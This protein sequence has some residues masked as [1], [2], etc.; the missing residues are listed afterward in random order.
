LEPHCFV[1]LGIG[2]GDKAW[3]CGGN[4]LIDCSASPLGAKRLG[5]MACLMTDL[6]ATM[7]A[8][9]EKMPDK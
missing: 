9:L 7:K 5:S 4:P 6:Q 8:I 3:V 2:F 1:A